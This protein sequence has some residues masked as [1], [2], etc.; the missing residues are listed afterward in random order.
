MK[1]SDPRGRVEVKRSIRFFISP[2]V[3]GAM[4]DSIFT[5]FRLFFRTLRGSESPRQLA[6]GVALGMCVGLIPNDSLFVAVLAVLTLSTKT[7]LFVASVSAILFSWAG[8]AGDDALHRLGVRILTVPAWQGYFAWAS[9]APILPWTRFNNTVV[10]G[11]TVLSIAV[12][13]PVYYLSLA[14]FENVSPRIHQKLA[15][16]RV[17][18]FLT[19]TPAPSTS[20]GDSI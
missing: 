5:F 18:R 11:S 13:Y 14:F 10:M 9:Q 12:F 17:Y 7:N 1:S 4:V 20:A 8:F 2:K 3:R 19:G 6:W 16:F 15:S